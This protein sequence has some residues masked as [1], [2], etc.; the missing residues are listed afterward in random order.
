MP[1]RGLAFSRW[2]T[3]DPKVLAV[4]GLAVSTILWVS[5]QFSRGWSRNLRSLYGLV[6]QSPIFHPPS[7]K[8]LQQ[9]AR[10]FSAVKYAYGAPEENPSV[11]TRHF[12][13][14][15]SIFQP[16]SFRPT[17][18]LSDTHDIITKASL[19]GDLPEFL[20]IADVLCSQRRPF[21][22]ASGYPGHGPGNAQVGDIV[23]ILGD[24]S[25]LSIL[26]REDDAYGLVGECFINECMYGEAVQA[27]KETQRLRGPITA[28]GLTKAMF[29]DASLDS[30]E[31][32]AE[33]AFNAVVKWLDEGCSKLEI[34]RFD[35]C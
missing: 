26:P 17:S 19:E 33:E 18:C 20:N 31:K 25:M 5:H 15:L 6:V 35:I 11:L 27:A 34:Q 7:A 4:D 24:A 28:E 8:L 1:S 13:A 22:T 16:D 23:A 9:L 10:A 21:V 14:F 32:L 2:P 29:L 30:G 3:N 12:A